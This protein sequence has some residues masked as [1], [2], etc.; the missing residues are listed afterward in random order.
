MTVGHSGQSSYFLHNLN[1]KDAKIIRKAKT[2]SV[3]KKR[4]FFIYLN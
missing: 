2:D 3:I 4:P 1:K